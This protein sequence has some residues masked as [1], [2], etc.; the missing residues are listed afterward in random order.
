MFDCFLN[1]YSIFQLRI[2]ASE[3]KRQEKRKCKIYITMYIPTKCT[4]VRRKLN[5]FNFAILSKEQ[6]VPYSFADFQSLDSETSFDVNQTC[7]YV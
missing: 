2:K 6:T 4:R 3:Y 5:A 7:R 1:C